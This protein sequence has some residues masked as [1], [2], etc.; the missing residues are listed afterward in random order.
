MSSIIEFNGKKYD[1]QTGRV[2]SAG[3]PPPPKPKTAANSRII[4]V[5][6][7]ES[8]VIKPATKQ[9][10]TRKEHSLPRHKVEKSKTLMRSSVK[11][12]KHKSSSEHKP[13]A[14]VGLYKELTRE[15]SRRV[16]HIQKSSAI[17]K[18]SKSPPK[19]RSDITFTV[20]PLPVA[21]VPVPEPIKE[22]VSQAQQLSE[23]L[24]DAVQSAESHMEVFAESKLN[25]ARSNKLAYALA[26]FT[27][28]VLIGFAL[29]QAIPFVQVKMAGNK[30]GFAATLPDYAPSGYNL[31]NNL[32]AG[33]GL[34]TMSYSSKADNKNYQIT[35][36][37]SQWNS[38]SLLNNYV[39]PTGGEYERI[40]QNGRTVYLYDGQKYATWLDNGIWYRLDGANN[41]SND[42]LLRIVQGL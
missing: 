34:V 27:S 25:S 41:F 17:V 15:R 32:E 19:Q 16:K 9:A 26:S 14:R 39:L 13:P 36:T 35:Q 42:Q 7:E 8:P 30:A 20:K 6:S 4:E 37:P 1:S 23:K 2:I 12:H 33:N 24:E 31:D 10:A 38:D 29:Y 18:F 11:K 22:I 28:V 21:A 40:D 5:K 3:V